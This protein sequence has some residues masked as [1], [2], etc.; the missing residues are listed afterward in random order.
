MFLLIYLL[1][2]IVFSVVMSFVDSWI[3]R[4]FNIRGFVIEVLFWPF[5]LF[6][7]VNEIIKA[8]RK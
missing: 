6:L 7:F 5:F 4:S 2:G 3:D 8:F 1:I